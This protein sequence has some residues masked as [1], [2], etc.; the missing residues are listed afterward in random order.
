M[1]LTSSFNIL[2]YF[3]SFFLKTFFYKKIYPK[4]WLKCNFYFLYFL[5]KKKIPKLIQ[6]YQ[7]SNKIFILLFILNNLK[8]RTNYKSIDNFYIKHSFKNYFVLDKSDVIS[9]DKYRDKSRNLYKVQSFIKNFS[10]VYNVNFLFLRK[11]KIFN[12]SRYSRNR[13]FY[14]TG[15]YWCLYINIIAVVGIYFWFYKITMNYNY[16]WLILYLFFVSFF[17]SK[18]VN[19]VSLY[20]YISFLKWNLAI[21]SS[22]V[23]FFF[24]ILNRIILIFEK[25]IF[26]IK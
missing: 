23:I 3:Q 13:Q 21:L 24:K 20:S 17:F 26:L 19:L 15:V 5:N 11:F 4:K 7:Y 1:F 14:R 8:H 12:K 9:Q 16:F 25:I 6:D 2:L 22:V 18:I 10:T